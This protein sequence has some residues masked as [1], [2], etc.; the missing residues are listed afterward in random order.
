MVMQNKDYFSI[1]FIANI[2]SRQPVEN[3]FAV[4]AGEDLALEGSPTNP[5]FLISQI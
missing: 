5:C 2:S 1:K 4:V 3:T